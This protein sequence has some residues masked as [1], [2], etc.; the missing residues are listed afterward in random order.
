[1][2]KPFYE[3]TGYYHPKYPYGETLHYLRN[4]ELGPLE[5][6]IARAVTVFYYPKVASETEMARAK[7]KSI[8][9]CTQ[10]I[11]E[12]RELRNLLKI[13]SDSVESKMKLRPPRR[14]VYICLKFSE[15][16][17]FEQEAQKTLRYLANGQLGKTREVIGRAVRL[18]YHPAALVA[19]DEQPKR[20]H[21]SIWES[22]LELQYTIA[23]CSDSPLEN[24]YSTSANGKEFEVSQARDDELV[25]ISLDAW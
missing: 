7:A 23:Y 12:L 25:P 19:F 17:V 5:E 16:F 9:F 24:K 8:A 2:T 6:T 10:M 1:M 13:P 11:T 14:Q 4:A 22:F 3:F 21:T 15:D 18:L 20:I